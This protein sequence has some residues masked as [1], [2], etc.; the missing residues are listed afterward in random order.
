M[1]KL[2]KRV[3]FMDF[4]CEVLI[5]EYRN[6]GRTA[7]MLQDVDDKQPVTTA[8]VNIP[9]ASLEDDEVII[10]N[11]EQN[12]GILEVLE[13]AGILEPTGR[14]IKSGFITCPV[15]KLKIKEN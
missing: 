6:N 5:S 12:E 9:E 11:S 3:T 8:T 4:D 7:I 15:C 13:K 1:K 14:S 10:R 2:S